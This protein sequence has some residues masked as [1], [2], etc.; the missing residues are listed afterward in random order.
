MKK[1]NSNTQNIAQKPLHA[2][3]SFSSRNP[4][5]QA[6]TYTA[7]AWKLGLITPLRRR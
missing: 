1:P 5:R 7:A 3:S 4:L 6:V 2:K